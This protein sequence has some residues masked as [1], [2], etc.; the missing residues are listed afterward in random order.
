ML[1]AGINQTL[2]RIYLEVKCNVVILTPYKTVQEQ[3]SNQVLLAER[4]IIGEVPTSYY[5]LEGIS[6]DN[7]ID[8]IE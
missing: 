5:H 8:I 4:L 1:Q 3:I 6:T 7:A 2:H